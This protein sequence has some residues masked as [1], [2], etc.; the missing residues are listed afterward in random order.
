MK[1]FLKQCLEDLEPLTGI[2][3]YYYLTT[4]PD[5]ER[6]ATVLILGII[7]VL[8]QFPYIP[9]SDQQK[10]IRDQMVKDQNY[11]SLNSR[12]VW[13][14]LNA[15]KDVYWEKSQEK[16]QEPEQVGPLTPETE[17]MI[18]EYLAKLATGFEPKKRAGFAQRLK[19]EMEKIQAEDE[20]RVAGNNYKPDDN[21]VLIA[22]KKAQAA[23]SRGLDKLGLHELKSFIVDGKTI[24]ARD[25]EE[26]Q[27]MYIE[28]YES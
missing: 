18:S 7:E 8:K 12:T 13:K 26:A 3:Q 19:E 25:K 27:E 1:D 11:D 16:V 9:E 14:W 5:G 2:R 17:K 20:Q 4:D 23:R 10:I 28:I 6:K 24:V 22:E 15:A 21:L